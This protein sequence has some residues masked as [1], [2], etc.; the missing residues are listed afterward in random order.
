M[1]CEHL[2][3]CSRREFSLAYNH[4]YST[5]KIRRSESNFNGNNSF[6]GSIDVIIACPSDSAEVG[7]LTRLISIIEITYASPL[8]EN[9]KNSI[10]IASL[11]A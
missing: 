7:V 5:S 9:G 3:I 8:P 6:F 2:L 10:K 1:K 4:F 11:A